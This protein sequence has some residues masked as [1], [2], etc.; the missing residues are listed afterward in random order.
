MKLIFRQ[1]ELKLT[2]ITICDIPLK[3]FINI[4]ANC[5]LIKLSILMKL[6][7]NIQPCLK[8]LTGIGNAQL[9][10]YRKINVPVRFDNIY[11]E[12]TLFVINHGTI[13]YHIVIGYNIIILKL[14]IIDL[15][16]V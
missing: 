6:K 13:S 15:T 9:I 16:F 4:G 1:N 10:V 2:L 11:I 7:C 12:L 14:I 3:Y 5:S 8:C